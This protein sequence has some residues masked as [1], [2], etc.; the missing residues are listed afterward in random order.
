M[1]TIPFYHIVCMSSGKQVVKRHCSDV[2]DAGC[3]PYLNGTMC[4]CDSEKCNG[5]EMDYIDSNP[6][7]SSNPVLS[8]S[9]DPVMTV[10]VI[11]LFSV[12]IAQLL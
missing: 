9:V 8:S 3:E 7:L 10:D 12:I 11:V 2:H 1:C 6:D 4:F 5:E